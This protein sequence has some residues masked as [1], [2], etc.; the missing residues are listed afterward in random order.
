MNH[1][2]LVDLEDYNSNNINYLCRGKERRFSVDIEKPQ[3]ATKA[4]N[5]RWTTIF[6]YRTAPS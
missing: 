2:I 6:R 3:C 4:Y 5:D 1:Q